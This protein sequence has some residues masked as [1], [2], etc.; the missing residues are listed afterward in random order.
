MSKAGEKH[1]L[2][3]YDAQRRGLFATG[4]AV[5]GQLIHEEDALAYVPLFPLE[6]IGTLTSNVEVQDAMCGG[7]VGRETARRIGSIVAEAPLHIKL[8]LALGT[9]PEFDEK[10]YY[11]PR[12][13]AAATATAAAETTTPQE[14]DA[15]G[16]VVKD[17]TVPAATVT[18]IVDDDTAA[19]NLFLGVPRTD[20][21]RAA[22]LRSTLEDAEVEKR[23]ALILAGVGGGSEPLKKD[24]TAEAR[25]KEQRAELERIMKP[26]TTLARLI[27][28]SI[29]ICG[30]ARRDWERVAATAILYSHHAM[31]LRDWAYGI[32]FFRT[33]AHLNHSCSPSAVLI[34]RKSVV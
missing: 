3:S 21:E 11:R 31:N 32:C 4:S 6:S 15:D 10:E 19:L 25:E 34:D 7:A 17:A 22:I 18:A 8:A 23:A 26:E 13:E 1:S 9:L 29:A 12:S 28:A 16:A 30:S 14:A 5:P 33:L 20:I 2:L 24:E 27:E